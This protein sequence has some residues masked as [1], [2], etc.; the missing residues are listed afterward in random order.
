MNN[1]LPHLIDFDW[2]SLESIR[3]SF[4][5]NPMDFSSFETQTNNFF[6]KAKQ[7]FIKNM[8]NVLNR[9]IFENPERKKEWYSNRHDEKDYFT[10]AGKITFTKTLYTNK[11]TGESRYLID[12]VL[13]IDP[14]ERLSDNTKVKIIDEATQTSYRKAGE[15]ASTTDY[16]SK[17][18]VKDLMHS[19]QFPEETF[20][21]VKKKKQVPVLYIEADEDHE[22]LQFHNKKGDLQTGKHGTKNNGIISKLIYVH[23]GVK[24]VSENSDRHELVN[25]YFFASS[26]GDIDNEELW[27]QVDNYIQANYE[28]QKIKYIFLM[29][30]GGGWI[31]TALKCIPNLIYVL[32]EFH[33]NKYINRIS[34]KFWDSSDDVKK[35]LRKMI[36]VNDYA[37]FDET[38]KRLCKSLS[39]KN[40]EKVIEDAKYI[41]NNWN[42]C[43]LRL[44]LKEH[45]CGCSAEAHVSHVLASRMS[46]RPMAWCEL[47]N[48]NMVQALA[49]KK[50]N[51]SL[52]ELIAYQKFLKH[53]ENPELEKNQT[54]AKKYYIAEKFKA[55]A[56][57]TSEETKRKYSEVFHSVD[58]P[59]SIKR[60]WLDKNEV[61]F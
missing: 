31:K 21:N 47:G 40:K 34:R 4:I 30:D 58:L 2:K 51:K 33:L 35:A 6:E 50:N 54:D 29:A 37:K 23:E 28:T 45:I 59:A 26:C 38:I 52:Y 13:G 5:E 19:L 49:Y 18:A 39:D 11:T 20:E 43:F 25:P 41:A 36:E 53:Q 60:N 17:S 15:V 22:K 24:K 44:K 57:L 61:F 7:N 55:Q 42:A 32:D 48:G 9:S 10:T 1:K 12:D 16:V 27:N 8:L 56:I 14:Y 46:S 3:D